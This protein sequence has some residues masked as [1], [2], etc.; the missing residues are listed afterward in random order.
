MFYLKDCIERGEKIKWKPKPD[1]AFFQLGG[2]GGIDLVRKQYKYGNLKM[3]VQ[4]AG[5]EKG[6]K[7]VRGE[8]FL[9]GEG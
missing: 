7:R 9:R 1:I 8:W 2:K 6:V 3:E 4:G 5:R